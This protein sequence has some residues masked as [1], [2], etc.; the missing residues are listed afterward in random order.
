VR[1]ICETLEVSPRLLRLAATACQPQQQRRDTLVVEIRA[2]HAEVKARY[3]SPRIQKELVARG[4]G[5][6]VNTVAKLMRD[7]TSG[8]KRRGS[9][10]SQPPT[11]TTTCLWPTTSLIGSS[12]P[13]RPTRSGCR[14]HL[15]SH[16]RG[17]LYLAAVED[18]YSRAHRRLVDG[19]QHGEPTGRRCPGDGGP[20]TA[21]D[22]T[23]MAH[24]DRAAV[25]Q[26]AL[27]ATPWA[28]T[29]SPEA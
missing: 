23:L 26:R 6:C 11:P 4:Q 1:L 19:R 20:A 8:P 3:G 16:R 17:W 2:I 22:E 15:H 18:L 29:A 13:P 9:S 5:C 12:I 28:G 27:P 24:S 10:A 7:T 25:R 14:H 21:P